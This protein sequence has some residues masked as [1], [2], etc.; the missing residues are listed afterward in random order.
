MVPRHLKR[1]QREL[2]VQFEDSLTDH[3]LHSEEGVFG[4]LKRALGG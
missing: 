2:L 1:E 3:N 4:K